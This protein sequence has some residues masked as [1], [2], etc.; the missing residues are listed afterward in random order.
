MDDAVDAGPGSAMRFGDL[1]EALPA[2]VIEKDRFPVE[3]ERP[4]AD[5]P[6]FHLGPPHAGTNPLDNKVAFE[7][8]D[9]SDDDHDG[10]AQR[11]ARVDLLAEADELDVEPVQ[12]VEH[13]EEVLH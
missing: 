3:I 4:T 12:F 9:R 2:P 1:A 11:A 5:V 13:V 8:R 10:A 7:F 6:A